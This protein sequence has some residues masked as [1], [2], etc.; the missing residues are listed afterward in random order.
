MNIF[1]DIHQYKRISE[2][3]GEAS[4][5][6]AKSERVESE[7]RSLRRQLDRVTLACQAMWELVRENSDITEQM[8]ADRINEVDMRDG[9]ADGKMGHQVLDCPSCGRKTSSKRGFCVMC[10]SPVAGDHIVEA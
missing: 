9:V 6:K 2:V 10:G 5:A 3:S 8:L 7:M 4:S 1:F